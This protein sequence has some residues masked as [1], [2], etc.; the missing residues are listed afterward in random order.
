M[1]KRCVLGVN[2]PMCSQL[3]CVTSDYSRKIVLASVLKMSQ[4]LYKK[5][6]G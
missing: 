4:L 5:R 2:V 3:N 6:L 1:L